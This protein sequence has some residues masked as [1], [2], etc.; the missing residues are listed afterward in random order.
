MQDGSSRKR[1][2]SIPSSSEVYLNKSVISKTLAEL[3]R[4]R[5]IPSELLSRRSKFEKR[6]GIPAMY[7]F[8]D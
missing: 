8:V 1:I 7:G 2:D 6:H 5:W 4:S 3:A